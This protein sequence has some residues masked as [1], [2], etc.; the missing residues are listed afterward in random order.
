[1]AARLLAAMR[2]AAVRGEL[3][4]LP[5]S[6]ETMLL[7]SNQEVLDDLGCRPPRPLSELEDA[8]IRA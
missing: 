8:A 5:R 3:F 1:M 4:G 6:S 7:L 2:L